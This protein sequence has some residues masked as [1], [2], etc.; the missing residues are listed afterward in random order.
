MILLHYANLVKD[1]VDAFIIGSELIGLTKVRIGKSFPAVDELIKLAQ[2]VKQIVGPRVLVSYAADWSEYHHTEGGWFNLD[3]LWASPDIDFVGIDAYFPVTNSLSSAIAPED[4][5]NGWINGEGYD[6]YIDKEDLQQKPLSPEYAWKNLRYWWENTHT[7]PD[8]TTTEW[9]PRLKPIWFTEFG[10]PSVDK[11][12]NQPN[13]FFD[14]ACI[15]GGIPRHS[16]GEIDFL[17][18]RRA[19]RAFIE[20]WSTQEYIGEM[21]LWTWDARPYPAWPHM[22]IWRDG[23]LWEKGHWVNSKFGASNLASI[24]LEISHKC[25]I[26]IDNIDVSSVDQPVEGF[27]LSN[28]VTAIEAINTLRTA[29]FFDISSCGDEFI[30]FVKRGINK[31][32]F[33]KPSECLKLTANSYFK[34]IE[35][36]ASSTLGKIDLYF[37]NQDKDYD[38]CYKY[39]NNEATSY[40]SKVTMH[41]P[42]AMTEYEADN[43]GMMIIANAAI[44]DRI[45]EF[46]LPSTNLKLKPCDFVALNHHNKQYSLRIINV[47]LQGLKLIVTGIVD[48]KIN[49]LTFPYA[50]K[51]QALSPIRNIGD[52]LVILCLPFAYPNINTPFLAAYFSGNSQLPLYAKFADELTDSWTKVTNLFPCN[53]IASVTS[54]EQRVPA[55]IYHIDEASSI[56]IR[57]SK[58]SLPLQSDWHYAMFGQE[59]IG[60]RRI[61]QIGPE[62]YRVSELVRGL[63]GTEKYILC[64]EP[65]EDFILID[66][67]MNILPISEKIESQAIYFKCGNSEISIMYQNNSQNPLSPYIAKQEILGSNLHLKLVTRAQDD[68]NWKFKEPNQIYESTVTVTALGQNVIATT[69][70]NEIIINL[71]SLDLSG[72]YEINIITKS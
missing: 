52:K 41:L 49:Y 47:V 33:I 20:Y 11:A 51:D 59:L 35:I 62:L 32:I 37:I 29:Y 54:I 57:A 69:C 31:E 70:E 15:D 36:P 9:T 61:E 5:A 34:E 22:N 66:Y 63:M 25:Q 27:L 19:I 13:V 12:P 45:I 42:I 3:P 40:T 46:I 67:G 8:Q 43:I 60:F 50:K 4:I 48:N 1:H 55:T 6:Y 21:F 56:F 65:G 30:S 44:E 28:R 24:L 58:I 38:S 53:S 26:N 10:F 14:P 23:H 72:G 2:Q 18:Q 71:S 16:N 68:G 64:H 39:L 7:N 17:I